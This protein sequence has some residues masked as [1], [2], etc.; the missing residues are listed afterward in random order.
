MTL[1]L[2]KQIPARTMTITA[3]WCKRDFMEMSPSYRKIR[4]KTRKPMDTCH[5][6]GH[7]IADGEMMGLANF[8]EAG[9]KVLCQTCADELL[10]SD[11]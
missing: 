10:A 9:N 11:E 1:R 3:R 8:Y 7:K 4:C 2:S 6:C 5:W